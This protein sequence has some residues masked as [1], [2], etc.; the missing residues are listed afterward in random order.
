MTNPLELL[1]NYKEGIEVEIKRI[2]L[3]ERPATLEGFTRSEGW[4]I[5]DEWEPNKQK[6]IDN[7]NEQKAIYEATISILNEI[8]ELKF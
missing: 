4:K 6:L 7:L 3:M 2:Y 8:N 1:I 5:R